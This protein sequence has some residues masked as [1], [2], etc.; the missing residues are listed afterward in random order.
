VLLLVYVPA[1][2]PLAVVFG[3]KVTEHVDVVDVADDSVH[4][5]PVN[6]PLPD[7][8]VN[9][10]VPSGEPNVPPPVFVTVTLQVTLPFNSMSVT[11]VTTVVVVSLM[12]KLALVPLVRPD[13]DAVNV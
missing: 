1:T 5:L 3:E 9:A 10:T 2:V 4:G 13:A 8:R 6:D 11:H 12:L 7:P